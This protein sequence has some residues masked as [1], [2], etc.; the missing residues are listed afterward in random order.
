MSSSRTDLFLLGS[1][2]RG[3]LQITDETRQ[4]IR[5]SRVVFV[6]HDDLAVHDYIRSL[7]N[8]VRDLSEMYEGQQVRSEVYRSISD[9]L[10]SEALTAPGVSFVVHGHPLFLVS[11]TEYTLES[12]RANGLTVR[13]LPGLSSFDTLLCDLE[14][15]YGYG[16]QI[17]DSTTMISCRWYPNPAIPALIFQLATTLS[18]SVTRDE[19]QPAV[20]QPL[21]Q[22]LRQIYP[23]QQRCVVVHSSTH[24]MEGATLISTTLEQ[25]MYE[26]D[27]ALWKRPTL[28]V[29]PVA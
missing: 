22:H 23:G 20:L 15:D 11:A 28:Y 9:L 8:D 3:F 12:A 14:I 6:L 5:A 17:F 26:P 16:L 21:I 10:V 2:I 4:A 13:M 18:G 29:P 25:L 1:G 27:L 19:P 24:V 7:C